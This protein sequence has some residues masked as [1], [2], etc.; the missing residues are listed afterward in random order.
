ME[1]P[2]IKDLIRELEKLGFSED[3]AKKILVRFYKTLKRTWG[4]NPNAYDF[5]KKIATLNEA[6]KRTIDL[7]DPNQ[8][9]IGHLKNKIKK[10]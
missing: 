9:F 3:E 6:T 8:I 4:L 5:A 1:S 2:Y 7:S 10:R